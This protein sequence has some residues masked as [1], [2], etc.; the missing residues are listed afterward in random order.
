MM[1]GFSMGNGSVNQK[2][3]R[4]NKL[5]SVCILSYNNLETVEESI[6]S[7]Y[8]QENVDMELIVSDDCSWDDK[9]QTQ[10]YI[11]RIIEPYRDKFCR[12]VINVNEHRLGT[13][14]HLN[15]VLKILRGDYYCLL[16]SGD[17]LYTSSVLKDVIRHLQENE[18]L[19]CTSKR[20]SI[21]A[22]GKKMIM[23]GKRVIK[24]YSDEHRLLALCCREINYI[25]TI[26]TFFTKEIFEKYGGFDESYYL[27]E[28]APFFLNLMFENEPISFLNEITCYYAPGGIS[29][30]K[31]VNSL[32][33]KDSVRTL[34]N[35][36]YPRREQL[37]F[38]TRRIVEFKFG[39]RQSDN[40]LKKLATAIK[41]PDATLYMLGYWIAYRTK[42]INWS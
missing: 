17:C 2:T 9:A 30:K 42:I 28:D 8:Q 21:N 26:G 10:N 41:Y 6:K 19:I 7:V 29:N 11:E 1:P 27:L 12:V 23:P 18:T 14:K 37:D 22:S 24:A 15:T 20:M 34:T 32:L 13:V 35:I 36:K 40:V 16:G 25:Y 5:F 33:E 31:K 38:F 39:V 4:E 3:D